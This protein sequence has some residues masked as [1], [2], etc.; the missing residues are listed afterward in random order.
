MS[1]RKV[2]SKGVSSEGKVFG[3]AIALILSVLALAFLMACSSYNNNSNAVACRGNS[4]GFSN[5]SLA[6]GSQWTYALSGFQPI[7]NTTSISPYREAGVFTADGA[8]YHERA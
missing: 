7:S 4:G 3:S 2:T 8:I 6:A 1:F 5:A